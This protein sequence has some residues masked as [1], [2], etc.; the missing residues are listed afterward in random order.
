MVTGRHT[1]LKPALEER[2]FDVAVFHSTGMGGMAFE[3][4]AG[5]G[6]FACVMDFCMQE[7]ANMLAGSLV[8]SG[9]D[10]LTGAGRAGVPQMVAPGALDLLDFAGW[11]DIPPRY[12]DRPLHEHN[13]LI[14]SAVL[15]AGELRGG[16]R[17]M[18]ARLAKATGP[19]RFFLP[20]RGIE[21]WDR[22]GGQAHDPDALAA[23]VDEARAVMP[24][25]VPVTEIGAHIND[26]AFADAVLEQF[27]AWVEQGVVGRG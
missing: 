10:R 19:T 27:D 21:E 16:I 20:L 12:A 26:R 17:E 8:S 22:A 3:R 9:A 1:R 6:A 5:E 7:L 15:D 14:R 13:R 18:A 11:Q 23:L 24:K 25:V 2:G 4:L